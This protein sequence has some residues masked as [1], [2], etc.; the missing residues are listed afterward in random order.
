MV[1]IED[2][3]KELKEM[4]EKARGAGFSQSQV[5]E[6]LNHSFAIVQKRNR[7]NSYWIKYMLFASFLMFLCLF[8][9]IGYD[10]K[11]LMTTV[12]RNL[13]NFI[14]P[15]LKL[16]RILA[17][18]VIHNYP[19]LSELYDEWCLIENPLFYVNEMD[20]GPCSIVNF[21][22]DLMNHSISRS[23]DPGIPYCKTE[24]FTEL[25]MNDIRRLIQENQG[26]FERNAHKVVSNNRTYRTINDLMQMGDSSM[27]RRNHIG[28]RINR[29]E[30]ARIVRELFP[31]PR[32]T[33][34]WF[35]QSIERFI[36]FDEAE[37]PA[38]SLP[39]TECANVMVRVAA[40]TRLIRIIA[41]PECHSS[42]EPKTVL[43]SPGKILWYNWWYWRPVSLPGGVDPMSLTI[44]YI[45][46]FC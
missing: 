6:A 24:D 18:S 3:E 17:L 29:M 27:E 14:Y 25:Q 9:G 43:L 36:L 20:C 46:S 2:Y 1:N 7:N 28:W 33:P 13:Q 37:S 5:D 12:Q 19:S 44:T 45:A 16:W 4:C 8:V 23:F 30:P 26:V 21:V 10:R 15:G 32:E 40:G 22:P 42:C 38:Y 39:A 31:R 34:L 11:Y 35:E 41:S